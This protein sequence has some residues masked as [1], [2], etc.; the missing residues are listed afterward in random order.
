MP[1][2]CKGRAHDGWADGVGGALLTLGPLGMKGLLTGL[3]DLV[4]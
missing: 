3:I 2:C 4:T 1:A